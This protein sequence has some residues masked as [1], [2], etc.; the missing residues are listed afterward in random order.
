MMKAGECT[1]PG[2]EAMHSR[3][4]INLG[5]VLGLLV[6]IIVAILFAI[7]VMVGPVIPRSQLQRLKPGMTKS[8]VTAILGPPRIVESEQEW[9]YSRTG[10]AGWVE[11]YF[12]VKGRFHR[13]NDES[14]F[15]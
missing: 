5:F 10:N 2:S 3:R 7:Y 12:D 14:P 15:P 6:V 8:E 9:V 13:V 4:R 11:V 1:L